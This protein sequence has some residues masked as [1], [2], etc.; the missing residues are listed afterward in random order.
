MHRQGKRRLFVIDD[1]LY[2]KTVVQKVLYKR[3]NAIACIVTQT[4]WHGREGY[5]WQAVRKWMV[6]CRPPIA[7]M[8]FV[9]Y[10]QGQEMIW[11]AEG[12]EGKG[13]GN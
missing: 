13:N 10:R 4:K 1:V 8:W 7:T 3:N 9:S 5:P 12:L 2:R 6:G 11:R